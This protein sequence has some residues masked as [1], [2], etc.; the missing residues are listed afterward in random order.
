MTSDLVSTE[1]LTERLN[2]PGLRV[3]DCRWILNEPGEGRRQ[4][5]SAH[6]PKALHLDVDEHLSGKKEKGP[7][8]HPIPGRRFFQD[9]LSSLGIGRDVHVVAY[10][11]GTGAPATRLWW[12]LR[13]YG[14]DMV[15]VL[16]GGWN[17]WTQ[18]SRPVSQE[19]PSFHEEKFEGRPRKK[20]AVDKAGVDSIRDEADTLLIDARAP[21]RY[22]G[23]AEPIDKR[24]GHI[25][26]AENFPFKETIDPVTGK[27]LS[28]EILKAQLQKIGVNKNRNIICYCGSGVTACTDIFALKLAGYEAQLYE[29]SWS[30]WSSDL[31]LPATVGKS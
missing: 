16:D 9:L 24:P 20:M 11:A 13:Y 21:E 27:F 12:L 25:P 6:I 31:D 5:D 10:D 28:P 22:R 2:A 8:R 4:Y 7:G 15:S 1:W 3:I 19:I 17:A 23:E 18:E 26:G 30:D 14:H 29:G